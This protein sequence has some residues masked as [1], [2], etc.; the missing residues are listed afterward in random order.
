MRN[1]GTISVRPRSAVAIA[2]DYVRWVTHDKADANNARCRLEGSLTSTFAVATGAGVGASTWSTNLG[3]MTVSGGARMTT[4]ANSEL[5]AILDLEGLTNLGGLFLSFRSLVPSATA[6]ALGRIWTYQN[7]AV[8]GAWALQIPSGGAR[9]DL[10]W[11][12]AENTESNPLLT[13]VT[14]IADAAAHTVCAYLDVKN[15]TCTLY[16]DGVEDVSAA[17]PPLIIPYD[18]TADSGIFANPST[19]NNIGSAF[20][21]PAFGDFLAVRFETDMSSSIPTLAAAMHAG[22]LSL[23]WALDGL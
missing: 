18:A 5:N 21:N 13:G 17:M 3:Y 22:G 20:T 12:D 19:S 10:Y 11:R 6:G 4:D 15:L 2:S 9:V 23:P 7:Q 16:V 14:S 8:N 1:G